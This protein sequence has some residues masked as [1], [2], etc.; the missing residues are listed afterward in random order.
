[1]WKNI[2]H[3]EYNDSEASGSIDIMKICHLEKKN[4]SNAIGKISKLKVWMKSCTKA[5]AYCTK[6]CHLAYV[7]S[8]LTIRTGR[9]TQRKKLKN[10][11]KRNKIKNIKPPA[12]QNNL[13]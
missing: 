7:V 12:L 1:M 11:N 5:Y 8:I 2:I 9:A 6:T 13:A 4:I 3:P 10:K